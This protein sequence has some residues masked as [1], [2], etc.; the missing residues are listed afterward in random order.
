MQ[1][2]WRVDVFEIVDISKTCQFGC[3]QRCTVKSYA[4]RSTLSHFLTKPIVESTKK[5]KLLF[6]AAFADHNIPFRFMDH[7]SSIVTSAFLD[8]GIAQQFL[9]KR[10]QCAALTYNVLIA[11]FKEDMFNNL[12]RPTPT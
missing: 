3:S 6:C 2:M 1:S 7:L 12:R 4:G 11:Q 10:S 5:A 9:M 8:S